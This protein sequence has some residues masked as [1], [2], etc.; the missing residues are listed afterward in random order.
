MTDPTTLRNQF[1]SAGQGHVFRFW[2]SLNAHDR[3]HLL[4][5]CAEVDL[6]EVRNL[7]ET[8]VAGQSA[9]GFDASGLAPIPFLEHPKHGGDSALWAKAAATGRAHL[10]AGKVA[11]LT[12]AGGQGTRLGYDGPK[13]TFAIT[14]VRHQ[15]LFA[16]FAAK[17]IGARKRHGQ[18]MP[19]VLMT[20]DVNHEPTVRYFKEHHFFGL[21]ESDVFFFRQGRMAAV[22]FSGKLILE[23]KSSLALSP[24][25]HGGSLRA[26]AR[27]G[28]AAE[29]RQRGVTTLS[30]F[31]VD[32]PLVRVADEAFL[33]HHLLAGSDM[34]SKTLPKAHAHEKVGVFALNQGAPGIVEYSDLPK[35]LAEAHDSHGRLLYRAGNPAIHAIELAFAERLGSGL[36]TAC[37]L[38]FHRAD[39]KIPCVDAAGNHVK[40]DKANGVKFEMFVF[41]ALPFARNPLLVETLRAEDFS[42][43]KNADGADSP[44][45]CQADLLRL[46]AAWLNAAGAMVPVDST[47][48][49]AFKLEIDF[50]LAD[51]PEDFAA[52]WKSMSRHPSLHEG[53][54]VS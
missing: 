25:G 39:K 32:N 15:S 28:V 13:G 52:A 46:H 44:A 1:E 24:D 19:W 3:Q 2:D 45:T 12:V 4:N 29:L 41:D 22:D 48:L 51:S 54:V 49:P 23:T 33:G 53:V 17:I 36:D 42:P 47:G 5:E 40:P 35:A 27:S 38:P 16:V 8:L 43:V 21:P 26:L 18:P 30:Y 20:S 9:G 34:S 6:A 11:F 50:S 7:H 14:P 37:R 31:Q 10:R